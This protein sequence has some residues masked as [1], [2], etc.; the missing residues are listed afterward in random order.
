M[1]IATISH[2][3]VAPRQQDFFR[4]IAGLGHQVLMLSPAVWGEYRVIPALVHYENG[5]SFE[6]V[7][8]PCL[9]S[10]I[11]DYQLTRGYQHV[12]SF[13]PDWLYIQ[14][15]PGSLQAMLCQDYPSKKAIFTWENIQE[16]VPE[17]L[18]GYDLGIG[19]S[20]EAVERLKRSA[21][22]MP[23]L[24]CLQVGVDTDHFQV[25]EGLLRAV[26]VGY[27][28]RQDPAKGINVLK[29]A[30]PQAHILPWASYRNL[31]WFLSEL[32]VLVA[33]S[34]DTPNWKE[35]APNYMALEA[36][37]CGCKIVHSDTPAMHEGLEGCPAAVEA[38]GANR[39]LEP[40]LRILNLTKAIQE[41]LERKVD[42]EAARLWVIER[43]GQAAVAKALIS[44][45]EEL[46]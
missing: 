28:G 7:P 25:R 2:S 1:R 11:Y 43:Y 30:W 20:R 46:S 10:G 18:R 4:Y 39:D 5:G 45:L 36:I 35:Q 8:L 34:L 15:E 40:G 12:D 32:Q 14:A 3:H 26:P 37:S 42:P 27:A 9:G 21:P 22:D 19:G 38:A 33:Y 41:A 16:L 23:T 13:K 29:A 17:S 31:P 24:Q 44:K 6:L